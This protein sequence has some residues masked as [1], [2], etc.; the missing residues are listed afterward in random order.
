MVRASDALHPTAY[1]GSAQDDLLAIAVDDLVAGRFQNPGRH[2]DKA[3]FR[4]VKARWGN[5]V[6]RG[7]VAA[8]VV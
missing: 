5:T 6:I 3:S 7:G 1:R 8:G 4:N 2:R